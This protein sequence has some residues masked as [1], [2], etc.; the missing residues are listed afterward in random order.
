[1]DKR[2]CVYEKEPT[3]LDWPMTN[4]KPRFITVIHSIQIQNLEKFKEKK[5]RHY[6]WASG[7]SASAEGQS[8]KQLSIGI[9]WYSHPFETHPSHQAIEQSAPN[10]EQSK[11]T[12]P[13]TSPSL[14][15]KPIK[16]PKRTALLNFDFDLWHRPRGKRQEAR[17]KE[18]VQTPLKTTHRLTAPKQPKLIT[19]IWPQHNCHIH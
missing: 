2:K 1:M 19:Y 16:K 11:A 17:G 14:S 8:R 5:F 15:P 3:G 7:A 6:L 10:I 18:P 4:P 12:N 13:H 9:K